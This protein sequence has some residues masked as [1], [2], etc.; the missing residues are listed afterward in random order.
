MDGRLTPEVPF[1][2][3]GSIL[4]GISPITTTMPMSCYAYED[5]SA[6]GGHYSGDGYNPIDSQAFMVPFRSM[7][8]Y[9]GGDSPYTSSIGM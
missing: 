6:H 4:G 7:G 1:S 2:L 3:G 5:A 9:I 8:I